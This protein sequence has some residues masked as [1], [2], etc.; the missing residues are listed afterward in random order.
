MAYQAS[1]SCIRNQVVPRS[2]HLWIR[3]ISCRQICWGRRPKW[4]F[5]SDNLASPWPFFNVAVRCS[6]AWITFCFRW[7]LVAPYSPFCMWGWEVIALDFVTEICNTTKQIS[8]AVV[9]EVILVSMSRFGKVHFIRMLPFW[10]D[11]AEI[12]FYK[13]IRNIVNTNIN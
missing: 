9:G 1:F 5:H 3:C 10:G 11:W 8:K 7:E 12:C 13:T 4:N 6:T 2:R